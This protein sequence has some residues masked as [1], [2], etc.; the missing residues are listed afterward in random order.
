MAEGS[1]ASMPDLTGQYDVAIGG[2]GF[3]LRISD[4]TPYE[5]ATAQFKREQVDQSASY[6]DHSLLG[7]WTVGQM[8][9]HKGAGIRFYDSDDEL[10]HHRF[11]ESDRLDPFTQPGEVRLSAASSAVTGS[12]GSL[13]WGGTGNGFSAVVDGGVFN[14]V[15]NSTVYTY[16]PTAGTVTHAAAGPTNSFVATT[17]NK[18]EKVATGVAATPAANAIYTHSQAWNGLWY[19][20]DRLWAV[21]STGSFYHLAPS[22]AAPPVAVSSSDLV[23]KAGDGWGDEWCLAATPGPVV[24]ANGSRVYAVAV[25]DDGKV[26]ALSGPIQVAELPIGEVVKGMSYYLGFLVLATS[27]GIRVGVVADN[28][29]VTYGPLLVEWTTTAAGTTLAPHGSSV[30]VAGVSGTLGSTVPTVY[31]VELAQQIG[32]TLEFA[33]AVEGTSLFTGSPSSFG[34]MTSAGTA[35]QFYG[36]TQLHQ[37]TPGEQSAS[38]GTLTT[39]FHRMGTLEP[40]KFHTVSVRV[41]GPGGTIQV[42]KILAD[43]T[44]VSLY[45][46]DVSQTDGETITMGAGGPV[47]M[48]GLKFTLTKS[49]SDCPVLL[50]YQLKAMPAPKR[51]RLIRLPLM[52]HD[53]E[54]RGPT[55]P[56]GHYGSAW[57]R[58]SELEQMEETGGMFLY[59]D[60]R[61]G[62]AAEVYI[63]SI[64]H[65]GTTPSGR[66]DS[67]FGGVVFLTLRKL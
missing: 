43:G 31:R 63:E 9:F 36:G 21:D 24:V 50:G 27:R 23:F 62:E 39:A 49:G 34:L 3:R 37:W 11:L 48:V 41:A 1:S 46:I 61:T 52:L 15:R 19:A 13:T 14:F 59:Q 20:K 22:P 40:K 64:E 30:Y 17:S 65:R 58:L 25:A 56:T 44:S 7:M 26:P 45:T 35:V 42:S 2:L 51:Q 6:G 67:G 8:S 28:G 29:T 12:Y 18:I 33:W 55:R 4:E 53:V 16:T 57:E 38:S 5:R 54:Q 66:R 60:F 10:T 32:D 47:E